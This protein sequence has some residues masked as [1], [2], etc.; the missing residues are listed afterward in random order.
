M[1]FN[2]WCAVVFMTLLSCQALAIESPSTQ[3]VGLPDELQVTGPVLMHV[4]AKGVQ[5]YTCVKSTTGDL[6]WV[7]KEPKADFV[8]DDGT[9][10]KH[11]KGPSW[12]IDGG[13]K[14]IGQKLREHPSTDPTAV[15]WLLL[16]VVS[17]EGDGAFATAVYVQRLN[18][19]GGKAPAITDQ[20]PGD[21][22]QVPYTAEYVF[23]GPG[24][25]TRP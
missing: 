11:F 6:K 1:R 17:H 8:A 19:T 13:A 24:A 23:Y 2:S 3:P 21:E 20:K 15:P 25:T 4:K 22:V 14:V 5:I 18:T 12:Q 16:K 9:K 10:G 7:M